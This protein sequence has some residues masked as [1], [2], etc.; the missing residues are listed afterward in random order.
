ML[1]RTHK[2]EVG[3][4]GIVGHVAARGEPRIALD[5]GA[6][7]VYF[8]SPDLPQTRSEMAL[9]LIAHGQIIGV[10]D[11]Q[12]TKP[13]A[14]SEE[15]TATLQVLADQVA[16]AI[17]NSRLISEMQNALQEIKN[18]YELQVGQ[19]WQ[20]RL[21]DKKLVYTYNR[22]GAQNHLP[23]EANLRKDE[24]DPGSIAIPIVFR[25]Y[26][27]GTVTLRKEEDNPTWSTEEIETVNTIVNQFSL[28]LE[29]A[30]LLEETQRR[31]ERERQLANITAKLRASNDPEKILRTAAEE[32]LQALKVKQSQ[33]L[34]NPKITQLRGV[35][36]NGHD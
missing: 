5:V 7:A 8:N 24:N 35:G 13:G 12:S 25:G 15:D 9:P 23:V 3:K 32:L 34:V 20:K 27:L 17:D 19:A 11:V 16:L 22:L 29:N 30:R 14:F 33:V 28:A 31:A 36:G 6:D 18:L 2:L 1:N 21:G 10:L 4:E 26:Q